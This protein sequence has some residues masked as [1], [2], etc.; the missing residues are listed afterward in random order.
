[1]N[2]KVLSALTIILMSVSS[3]LICIIGSYDYY[4]EQANKQY[5]L[6]STEYTPFDFP[7][8]DNKSNYYKQE[9][10]ALNETA[11]ELNINYLKRQRYSGWAKINNHL[12]YSKEIQDVEFQTASITKTK[13]SKNFNLSPQIVKKNTNNLNTTLK[14]YSVKIVPIS[15]T[16]NNKNKR[17]GTFFLE[18]ADSKKTDE[19]FNI[20]NQKV[21]GNQ[22]DYTASDFIIKDKTSISEL[23][24]QDSSQPYML[25]KLLLIFLLIFVV[26][27]QLSNSKQLSIYKL[28]GIS[29]FKSFIMSFGKIWIISILVTI[30]CD[31]FGTYY[32]DWKVTQSIQLFQAM[33]YLVIPLINFILIDILQSFSFSNQI[34]KKNYN[35]LLFI[36]VYTLKG[37]AL[38]LSIYALIPLVQVGNNTFNFLGNSSMYGK[39]TNY[40][41]FYP[42]VVGNNAPDHKLNDSRSLDDYMYDPLNKKG[43]L[44]IDDS[45]LGQNISENIK[46]VKVNPNYLKEYPLY[47]VNRT[48][49]HVSDNESTIIIAIPTTKKIDKKALINYVK[50]ISKNE[51]GWVPKIKIINTSPNLN[52]SFI[53]I[54]TNKTMN[55]DVILVTTSRNSSFVQRNIMN[56]QGEGDGLKVPITKNTTETFDNVKKLLLNGNYYDNYP[57]IVSL[58]HLPLEQLKVS[59]GNV[60]SQSI[61]VISGLLFSTILIVYTTLIYFKEFKRSIIIKRVSGYSLILSYKEIWILMLLQYLLTLLFIFNTSNNKW[62]SFEIVVV[63]IILESVLVVSSIRYLEKKNIGDIVNGE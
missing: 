25:E 38:A 61:L 39:Q 28:H 30:V 36:G 37:L 19:F 16:L 21:Y 51:I 14:G 50:N 15:S 31:I 11:K 2:N 24:F 27:V 52:S 7:E 18:T 41:V 56:G 63:I 23:D 3:I 47:D 13:I 35:K 20:L 57:Q 43:S 34:N 4:S 53:N 33:I 44:I 8:K 48:K 46:F 62:I 59:L 26:V 22:K 45:D 32:F 54:N 5:E 17:E 40:G 6:S 60:L 49:I 12:N 29:T 55:K 9:I 58:E 1:M 10:N 42:A